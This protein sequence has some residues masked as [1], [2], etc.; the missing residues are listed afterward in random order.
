M[1]GKQV[2]C[3]VWCNFLNWK[4]NPRVILSFALA[5][6][7]AFLLTDKVL[8]IAGEL[9]TI[10][11]IWEPFIWT[12]GDSN[13][14][15]LSAMLLVMIFADMPFITS[16]TPFFLVRMNRRTWLLGQSIYMILTT[17]IYMIFMMVSCGV[18][19][20]TQSFVGNMWSETAAV[21]GYSNR[22]W[23]EQIPSLVRTLESGS[24]YECVIHTF[25]LMLLYTL[26]QMFVMLIFNLWRGQ[27]AGVMS[28]VGLSICGFL[29]NPTTIQTILKLEEYELY[30]ANVIT[31]WMSPLNQA[32]YSMHSFG[33]DYLPTLWQTYLIFGILITVCIIISLR[34]MKQYNFTFTVTEN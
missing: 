17:V 11:Q 12:F 19:A 15:L 24:P 18:L 4:R 25:C 33:Y 27:I 13:S 30:I 31:G 26:L 14:I 3:I 29:L 22:G 8:G 6:I 16:G 1:M 2:V 20:M 32:T 34:L 7:L 9:G 23:T 10:L 28:I 21:L 5:F